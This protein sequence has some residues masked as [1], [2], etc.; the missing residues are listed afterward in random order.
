MEKCIVTGGSGF[1]GTHLVNFLRETGHQVV[2]IDKN[3]RLFEGRDDVCADIS[4][5]DNNL[6]ILE[7][8]D[9]AS[10]VFHLAALAR[11]QPSIERPLEFDK[12]NT[13]GTLNMLELSR[14]AGIKKFIFSSSSSLYGDHEVFPTPESQPA[15]PIS[16]YA[17]QKSIGEQYCRLYSQIHGLDTVNLRY[18]NVYG[19]GAPTEGAY[20]LVI[21]K[22][23]Q[24]F[25]AGKSLT[26]HGDGKQ[27]RDFTYVQDVVRANFL[28]FKSEK[29]WNGEAFNIGNGDNRS[30]QEIADVFETSYEYLPPVIEPQIT[31]ADNTKAKE[32]FGWEP[33]GNVL[34]WLK[35]HITTL[36]TIPSL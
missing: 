32:E 17:L 9:G 12:N 21:G 1:I 33:T 20:C 15:N 13:Y 10:C 23:I 28:A 4:N 11:V 16:P 24:Q 8:M 30:V 3:I 2:N 34:E 31:L 6:K 35:E 22:F 27:R 19:E 5:T 14:Q 18:F 7:A 25:L 26:I 29:V 36:P